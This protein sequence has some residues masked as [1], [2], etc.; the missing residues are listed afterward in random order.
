MRAGYQ[1]FKLLHSFLLVLRQVRIYV[2]VIRDGI[3]RTCF[4]LG[5]GGVVI[6]CGRVPDD[7][8]VPYM[9]ST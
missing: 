4:A 1:R 8:G 9:R 3:R 5:D 6:L 2:I 7:T